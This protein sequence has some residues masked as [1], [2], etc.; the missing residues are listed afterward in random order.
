MIEMAIGR[1]GYVGMVRLKRNCVNVAACLDVAFL[2]ANRRPGIAVAKILKQAGIAELRVADEAWTGTQQLTRS[3]NTV[4]SQRVF[5]VGDAAGYV[6]PFTGEGIAW[7]LAGGHAVAGCAVGAVQICH[8]AAEALWKQ[9]W[10]QLVLSHQKPCRGLAALLRYPSA[11]SLALRTASAFPMLTHSIIAS[12]NTP[13][14]EPS[15]RPS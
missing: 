2:R 10:K 1:E 7:A 13:L 5:V 6:E 4:A 9:Q 14:L 15:T 12:L 11:I 8:L 3:I